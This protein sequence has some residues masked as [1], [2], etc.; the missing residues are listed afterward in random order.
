MWFLCG[1]ICLYFSC[2]CCAFPIWRKV[3]CLLFFSLSLSWPHRDCSQ[4]TIHAS[5]FFVFYLSADW[6]RDKQREREREREREHHI[7][8]FTGRK[9]GE[10]RLL[11][12]LQQ[13]GRGGAGEDLYSYI[14]VHRHQRKWSRKEGRV[15][16]WR[17]RAGH[18]RLKRSWL[19]RVALKAPRRAGKPK[20]A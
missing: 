7:V 9:V 5:V 20:E 13:Q 6:V 4:D 2:D 3:L 18:W 10:E 1:L 19:Q 11:P 15:R 16:L 14:W 12:S 17:N 8:S